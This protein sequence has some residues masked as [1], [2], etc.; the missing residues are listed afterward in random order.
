MAYI[1][2]IVTPE[3]EATL[4]RRGWDV[5]P[6]PKGLI[7]DPETGGDHPRGRMV[8]VDADMLSIMSGPDWDQDEHGEDGNE[9]PPPA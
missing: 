3:Q 8:F 7:V 4:T 5:E 2:G 6:A 9:L 1:V